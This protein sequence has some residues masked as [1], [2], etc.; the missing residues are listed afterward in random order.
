M[1]GSKDGLN[2]SNDPAGVDLTSD[3]AISNEVAESKDG[4]NRSLNDMSEVDLTSNG[5]VSN[6]GTIKP[7]QVVVSSLAV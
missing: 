7:T 3:G 5:A 1:T 6:G 2:G 4:M